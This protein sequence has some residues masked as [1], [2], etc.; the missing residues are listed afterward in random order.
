MKIEKPCPFCQQNVVNIV[1]SVVPD[2][3][4]YQVKCENCGARG[5][6]YENKKKAEEGWN[7][8]IIHMGKFLRQ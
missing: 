2:M 7:R 5:P 6:I 8:G 3:E 1:K 4:G